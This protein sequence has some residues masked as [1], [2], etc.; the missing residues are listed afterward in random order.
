MSHTDQSPKPSLRQR[1]RAALQ[2]LY[3]ELDAATRVDEVL[4]FPD[5]VAKVEAFMKKQG[6]GSDA[7]RIAY[8]HSMKS[9]V[10]R[11]QILQYGWK[12]P[13]NT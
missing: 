6:W 11:Q 12:R 4:A 3:D 5:R 10:G 13:S 9:A 7:E 8:D 1:A 2:A